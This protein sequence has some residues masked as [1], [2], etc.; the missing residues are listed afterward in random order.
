MNVDKVYSEVHLTSIN[1]SRYLLCKNSENIFREI[2]KKQLEFKDF[3]LAKKLPLDVSL[4]QVE[5]EDIVERKVDQLSHQYLYQ[6]KLE[7]EIDLVWLNA[8]NFVEPVKYS[9]RRSQDSL[10][11]N[12]QFAQKP[13]KEIKKKRKV[14]AGVGVIYYFYKDQEKISQCYTKL[15]F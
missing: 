15:Q 2:Q 9:K 1:G 12:P 4:D 10:P 11:R 3:M 5:V 7:G 14:E 13:E 6:V 8:H